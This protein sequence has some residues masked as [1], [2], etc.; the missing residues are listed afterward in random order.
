VLSQIDA[1]IFGD[2]LRGRLHVAHRHGVS[3]FD[4]RRQL[5]DEL[6]D[7]RRVFGLAFDD[8]LV[9]LRADADVQECFEMAEVFIVRPEQ[10]LDGALGNRNLA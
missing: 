1:G 4:E 7:A 10:R 3:L 2:Q 6:R 5:R 8:E 9:A